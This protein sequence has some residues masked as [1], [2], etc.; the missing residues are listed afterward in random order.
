MQMRIEVQSGDSPDFIHRVE[1]A[2]NGVL[3]VYAPE[4]L[5]LIKIDNWFG[6]KWLGFSGQAFFGQR[7]RLPIW[8]FRRQG[9]TENI[10]IPP[11]VPERVVSQRRFAGPDYEE[12]DPGMPVHRKMMSQMALGRRTSLDPPETALAWYSGSSAANG[13][14]AL[15]AY[16]PIESR[17]WAWY[18]GLECAESWRLGKTLLIDPERFERLR[19]RG[20]AFQAAS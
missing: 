13:R 8:N 4:T 3:R 1:E 20:K 6:F 7:A 14:G 17:C 19:E 18:V 2:V 16:I 11:F 12:A 15:M 10:R 5:V 9:L